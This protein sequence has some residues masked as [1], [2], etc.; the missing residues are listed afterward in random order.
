MGN[1][2]PPKSGELTR[3]PGIPREF[4]GNMQRRRVVSIAADDDN[5]AMMMIDSDDNDTIFCSSF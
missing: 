3:S 5:D 1:A 2:F 4:P